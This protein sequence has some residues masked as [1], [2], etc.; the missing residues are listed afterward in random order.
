P[1]PLFEIADA[2]AEH[3]RRARRARDTHGRQLPLLNQAVDGLRADAE[4]VGGLFRGDEQGR[5]ESAGYARL[6]RRHRMSCVAATKG[7]GPT[8]SRGNT[9]SSGSPSAA[10]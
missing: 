3:A 9:A 6:P 5:R 4:T 7:S 1:D 10:A 8:S 2:D